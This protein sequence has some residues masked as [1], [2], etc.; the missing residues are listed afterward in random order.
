[1]ISNPGID[2][3]VIPQDNPVCQKTDIPRDKTINSIL[4]TLQFQRIFK[5]IE[6]QNDVAEQS[7]AIIDGMFFIRTNMWLYMSHVT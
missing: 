3:G 5:A 4:D 2:K 6:L 7:C 1:M